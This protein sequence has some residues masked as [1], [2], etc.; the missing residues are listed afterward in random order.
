MPLLLLQTVVV[1]IDISYLYTTT[2]KSNRIPDFGSRV[3][4][5]YSN[6]FFN[7]TDVFILGL[8]FVVL[9]RVYI[10]YSCTVSMFYSTPFT[11]GQLEDFAPALPRSVYQ[12]F[13]G[14]PLGTV[15][16]ICIIWFKWQISTTFKCKTTLIFVQRVEGR[17]VSKKKYT[18]LQLI[19]NHLSPCYSHTINKNDIKYKTL[20]SI[21][22]K[23]L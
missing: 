20:N 19:W 1:V 18:T 5:L 23:V 8:I 22:K 12:C 11:V 3:H 9:H 7:W 4:E 16:Q 21:T 13:S 2:L 10:I 15:L 6:I 14:V 17:I